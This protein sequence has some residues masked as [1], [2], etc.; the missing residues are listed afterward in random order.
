V[1]KR[2]RRAERAR[3]DV[4]LGFR[5]P[6]RELEAFR[7]GTGAGDGPGQSLDLAEAGGVVA[8]GETQAVTAS[9]LRRP[10]FA[11]AGPRAGAGTRIA[12]VGITLAVGSHG[13][14]SRAPARR[15]KDRIGL[16]GRLLG[17]WS[18]APL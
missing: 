3:D 7:V 4:D 16:E 8:G 11:G 1:G 2:S 5:N 12:P 14:S 9:V 18:F 13:V 17:P 6:A 10:R 15:H